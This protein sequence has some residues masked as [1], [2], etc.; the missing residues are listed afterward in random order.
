MRDR[1]THTE[2]ERQK[3]KE[4]EKE[5]ERERERER[6][7]ET[8]II[9]CVTSLG[10]VGRLSSVCGVCVCVSLCVMNI[11]RTARAKR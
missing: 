2:R 11:V 3:E 1:H 6:E 10:M 5:G 7:R 9:V 8:F 4:R